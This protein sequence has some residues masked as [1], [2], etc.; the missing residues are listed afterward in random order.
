VIGPA[1]ALIRVLDFHVRPR[2][3][4]QAAVI[5]QRGWTGITP[6]Q[7]LEMPSFVLGAVER[8]VHVLEERRERFG[9]SYYVVSDAAFEAFAP[10]V[11][12]LTGR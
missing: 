4:F 1:A 12:A 8:L 7:V 5:H 6:E 2:A 11:A 9:L 3:V 10:V